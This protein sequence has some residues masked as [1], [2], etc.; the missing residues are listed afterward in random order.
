MTCCI[1]RM[2]PSIRQRLRAETPAGLY[3]R[4]T[5][6][7]RVATPGIRKSASRLNTLVTIRRTGDQSTPR[8]LRAALR[9]S[10][11]AGPPFDLTL[12]SL[13]AAGVGGSLFRHLRFARKICSSSS[14]SPTR[15]MLHDGLH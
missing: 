6:C 13:L 12:Y 15:G 14:S 4:Q 1:V 9:L 7:R 8:K 11:E 2:L 10:A 3:S 5:A